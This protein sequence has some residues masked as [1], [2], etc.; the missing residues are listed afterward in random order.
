MLNHRPASKPA[1]RGTV[2]SSQPPVAVNQTEWQRSERDLK[3]PVENQ[4]QGD[5]QRVYGKME[6]KY[7]LSLVQALF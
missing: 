7:K 5:L 2:A 1:N 3:G 6:L 4:S